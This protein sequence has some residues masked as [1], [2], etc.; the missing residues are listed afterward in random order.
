MTGAQ[1]FTR[2][3]Q[4]YRHAHI[5]THTHTWTNPCQSEAFCFLQLPEPLHATAAN[6]LYYWSEHVL[7]LLRARAELRLPLLLLRARAELRLPGPIPAPDW[8]GILTPAARAVYLDR[9]GVAQ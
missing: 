3:T 5:P 6:V 2:H 4:T 7:N 9:L 1:V 8:Q